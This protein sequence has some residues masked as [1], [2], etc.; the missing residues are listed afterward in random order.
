MTTQIE[1][2]MLHFN[3]GTTNFSSELFQVAS[4]SEQLKFPT[5][6]LVC[7]DFQDS[8]SIGIYQESV[9]LKIK[10]SKLLIINDYFSIV[11]YNL[12]EIWLLH[13][14]QA[15]VAI[16]F[17]HLNTIRTQQRPIYLEFVCNINEM[18]SA[19]HLCSLFV[20]FFPLRL[21]TFYR[22]HAPYADRRRARKQHSQHMHTIDLYFFDVK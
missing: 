7:Y 13:I 19:T 18:M 10:Y 4:C 3:V 17:L 5:S 21:M 8:F 12:F 9:S 2:R 15:F 16:V 22:S 11:C 14:L 6:H 20:S 1:F